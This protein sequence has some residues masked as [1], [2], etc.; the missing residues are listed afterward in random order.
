VTA[1]LLHKFREGERVCGYRHGVTGH[2]QGEV[3]SHGPYDGTRWVV[4]DDPD[5]VE[6]QGCVILY[7]GGMYAEGDCV[8]C[9]RATVDS[10]VG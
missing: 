8:I 9:D 1:P 6:M 2:V 10:L 4:P 5:H 7:V 3:W